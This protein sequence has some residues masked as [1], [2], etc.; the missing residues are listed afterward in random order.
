[1]TTLWTDRWLSYFFER[2]H[3]LPFAKRK[4]PVYQTYRNKAMKYTIVLA[5]CLALTV[6]VSASPDA[7]CCVGAC[8]APLEKYYS[9]DHIFNK[10]GECCMHPKDFW[11]FKIFELGLTKAVGTNSPCADTK[12]PFKSQGNY[13]KYDKTVTHGTK[14]LNMTLDMYEPAPEVVFKDS[15]TPCCNKPCSAPEV[16]FFSVDH[17]WGHSPFCGETCLDPKKFNLYH[18]F[19]KN[20]TRATVEHP[21]AAQF[22]PVGGHYSVYNKTVTHGVPGLLAVT[23]DL[24]GEG[25]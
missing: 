18:L 8:E 3:S 23:L 24:Y 12:S 15:H 13:T 11:K 16:K 4:L 22:D 14:L 19:E 20:L 25:M 17:G 10:C 2:I 6:A 1:M 9:V 7:K 21:C 5:T